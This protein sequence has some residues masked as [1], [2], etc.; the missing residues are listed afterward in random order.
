MSGVPWLDAIVDEA[1]LPKAVD[2]G[3]AALILS[4][5]LKRPVAAETLRR[6]P[7]KY[8][9]VAGG[10]LYAPDDLIA[11]AR[12]AYDEAP[13]RRGGRQAETMR[14]S[15]VLSQGEASP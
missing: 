3:A 8:K 4:L 5:M 7:I 15:R 1:K 6:W 13:L 12:K 14:R 10:A 9:L 2:R 11:Y